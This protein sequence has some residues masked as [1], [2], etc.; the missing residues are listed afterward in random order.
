MTIEAPRWRQRACTLSSRGPVPGGAL[1]SVSRR[2]P[3]GH[4]PLRTPRVA[5]DRQPRRGFAAG[6][7]LVYQIRLLTASYVRASTC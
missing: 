5:L 1:A 6:T 2:F 7:E 3:Q 4:A